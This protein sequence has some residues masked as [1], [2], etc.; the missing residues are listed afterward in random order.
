VEVD[1]SPL[2][3]GKTRVVSMRRG[4][5][6]RA[7]TAQGARRWFPFFGLVHDLPVLVLTA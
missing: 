3:A 4:I 5:A 1:E 7:S 6:R 2:A